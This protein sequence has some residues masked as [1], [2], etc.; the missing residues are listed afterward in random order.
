MAGIHSL[1]IVL[2]VNGQSSY[3]LMVNSFQAYYCDHHITTFV[4]LTSKMKTTSPQQVISKI[5]IINSIYNRSF[6]RVG[7]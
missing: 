6:A 7:Y 3:S 1:S 2:N 5:S 4:L